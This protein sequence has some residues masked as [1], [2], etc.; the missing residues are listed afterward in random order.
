MIKL[1]INKKY[2]FWAVVGSFSSI[3]TAVFCILLN[4]SL[5]FSVIV[6]LVSLII[7]LISVVHSQNQDIDELKKENN[8]LKTNRDALSEQY[9]DKAKLLE[10]YKDAWKILRIMILTV[11]GTKISEKLKHVIE[12][13]ELKNNELTK[14]EINK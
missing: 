14:E 7:T 4:I 3:L 2:G 8:T 10:L 5:L 13:Y 9:T 6:F 12:F 11:T 1:N